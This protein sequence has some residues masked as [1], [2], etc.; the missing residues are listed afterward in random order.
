MFWHRRDGLILL[1]I[2]FDGN[3]RIVLANFFDAAG[4]NHALVTHV[5][6]RIFNGT[7]SAVEDQYLHI[8]FVL[9]TP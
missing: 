3:K 7:A 4:R 9:D 2:E 8:S 5:I 6:E 1:A